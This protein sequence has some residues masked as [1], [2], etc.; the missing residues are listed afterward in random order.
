MR[1]IYRLR[2]ERRGTC[3]REGKG[4]R[5]PVGEEEREPE[6]GT[7]SPSAIIMKL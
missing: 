7:I 2:R 3:K 6:A 4:E 5:R 1:D